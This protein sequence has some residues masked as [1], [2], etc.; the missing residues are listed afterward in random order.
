LTRFFYE[1]R[2]FYFEEKGVVENHGF[3][4]YKM[5][6]LE[7]YRTAPM[8]VSLD[9]VPFVAA[10]SHIPQFGDANTSLAGDAHL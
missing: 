7:E 4:P 10:V 6:V 9:R 1:I 2:N 5:K 3:F 8:S